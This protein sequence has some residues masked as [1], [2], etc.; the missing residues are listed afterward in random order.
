MRRAESGR[1]AFRT[2]AGPPGQARIQLLLAA[3][4]GASEMMIVVTAAYYLDPEVFQRNF[5][6]K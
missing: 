3:R 1:K 4:V 2:L 5:G 6:R